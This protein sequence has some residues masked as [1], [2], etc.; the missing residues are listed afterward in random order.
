[1]P[2]IWEGLPNVVLEAML[3][4]LPV[5]ATAVGGVPEVV[6]DGE[7]GILVQPCSPDELAGAILRMWGD[8]D[9]RQRCAAAGRAFVVQRYA[10]VEREVAETEAV[11]WQLLRPPASVRGAGGEEPAR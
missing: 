1:M 7:T 3:A 11:Y 6:Q 2:S 10:D 8:A 9:L 5:I 4:G